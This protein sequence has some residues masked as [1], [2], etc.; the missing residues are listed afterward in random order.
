LSR[1]DLQFITGTALSER[2]LQPLLPAVMYRMTRCNDKDLDALIFLFD[3]ANN[4]DLV[5]DESTGMHSSLS[6]CPKAK[7]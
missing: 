5:E 1:E 2:S 6:A 3:L 4:G 7:L